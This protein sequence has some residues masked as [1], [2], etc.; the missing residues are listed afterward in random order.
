MM[1]DDRR[2]LLN[3]VLRFTKEPRPE[4]ITGRGK[5]ASGIKIDRLPSQRVKLSGELLNMARHVSLQPR[6]NDRAVVY[7]SMFDDSLA[8]TW[9]PGDLFQHAYGARLIAPYRHGYLVEMHLSS[10]E[11][12]AAFV[13]DFGTVRDQVDISRVE[14]IRYFKSE[15]ALGDRSM[16]ELWEQAPERENGRAF[17]VSLMPLRDHN[18]TEH[19]LQVFARLRDGVIAP[20]RRQLALGLADTAEAAGDAA[21]ARA[22]RA[23]ST[24]D[25][26]SKALRDYRLRQRARTTVIVPGK[27]KLA[28]LIASGAVIR[29]DPVLPIVT[30]DPGTGREPDRPLPANL[31]SMPIVG[32]VDGGLSASSYFPAEAWRAPPLVHGAAAEVMHGNRVTSLVVQGHEWNNNLVLPALHCRVGTVAAI[33]KRGHPGPDPEELVD[34]LDAVMTA[35]PETRVW[36]LSFNQDQPCDLD[37]VSFLGHALAEL[38]RKHGVLL[39]NSIGNVPSSCAKRPADCEAALTVGG[40][41]QDADG[42]PGANCT[43]S[44]AGPG[45]CGMLKPDISH[46]SHVRALGGAVLA[47]SSFATA[48]ASPLAAHTMDRLREP[49][50]D[51]VRAL[52]IHSADGDSFD[53]GM[54]FGTPDAINLPWECRPGTVTL[55]WKASLRDRASYY[56][57]LPIPPALLRNG[58]LRGK[59]R[60]TAILNPH[61]MVDEFAGPNYF[62]ARLNTAVQYPKGDGFSNLLG[63]MDTDRVPEAVARAVDHKWCTVRHHTKDFSTRGHRVDGDMLRIYARI[64]TRDHYVYGYTSAD[65][66]PP[67]DAVF[68]LSLS[69]EDEGEDIYNQLRDQLGSFV[70]TSVVDT[71]IDIDNNGG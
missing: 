21:L 7:A 10:L 39:V 28:E 65:Q 33:A 40:R 2:P 4:S 26:I 56:W 5:S 63:S 51:L 38:A 17:F 37:A 54:G 16:D 12:F 67:L 11:R 70:E 35:H 50:P 27:D 66:V 62:S 25:R 43:V 42:K 1:V 41:L 20:P 8:P 23:I 53:T 64:Y 60:L 32:V 69:G 19:L 68:V 58:K 31:A 61:P 36:N 44:L 34:Y 47:G 24:P 3:P 48:L 57:E 55:Q 45:P 15:D 9:T 13:R 29:L 52:L 22:V 14:T 46:F 30:T 6:F 71:D 49:D 18:A 59:G